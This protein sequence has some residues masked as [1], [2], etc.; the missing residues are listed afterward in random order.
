MDHNPQCQARHKVYLYHKA[1][2]TG[3][4]ED[5]KNFQDPFIQDCDVD[6]IEKSWQKLENFIKNVT[7]K[8]IPSKLS[9]SRYNLPWMNSQLKRLIRRKE[10]AF[11]TAKRTDLLA[12]WNVID[13]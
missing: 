12:N 4:R 5:I 2:V 3:M 11:H 7:D 6:S 9:S 13:L 10:R 8:Y 1:D